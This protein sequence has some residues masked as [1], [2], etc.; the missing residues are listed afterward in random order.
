[1]TGV[2][3]KSTW[4]YNTTR[5][6][7]AFFLIISIISTIGMFSQNSTLETMM[8]PE[9]DHP[10]HL[11]NLEPNSSASTT[12]YS[13]NTYTIYAKSNLNIQENDILL[14]DI[15]NQERIKSNSTAVF[16]TMFNESGDTFKAVH[17]WYLFE[18]YEVEIQNSADGKLWLVNES[19]IISSAF[20]NEILIS[21]C[22]GCLTSVCLIPIIIIWFIIN[23]QNK[24][25]VEIKFIS[26]D[27]E[28]SEPKEI[29]HFNNRIP[30]SDELFRAINGNDQMKKELI[31][32]VEKEI[33]LDSVPAPFSDRPDN[34]KIQNKSNL[35]TSDKEV[36][37]SSL[38][39]PKEE[40]INNTITPSTED[41]EQR[42]K[43]W[44]G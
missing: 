16:Q 11:L 41:T 34:L 23:K 13:Q 36:I 22:F 42:W 18:D 20:D 9:K 33:E 5:F 2:S 30:N 31:Q 32:K 38:S 35:K 3:S 24:N 4:S 37:R 43:Q 1:M 17:T 29:I 28:F 12:L 26:P 7:L 8:N 10:S 40:G 27:Q 25:D 15:S 6:L 19:A 39:S 44:D 14:I 21:S